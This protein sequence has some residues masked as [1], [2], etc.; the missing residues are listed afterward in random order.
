MTREEQ[1]ERERCEDAL[2]NLLRKAKDKLG[3]CLDVMV[4]LKAQKIN[5][6]THTFFGVADARYNLLK[7]C[8]V[9]DTGPYEKRYTE[10]TSASPIARR[11]ST[12]GGGRTNTLQANRS[13]TPHKTGG[14]E[15]YT[16]PS[17][18]QAW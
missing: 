6:A 15:P 4:H 1:Q 9:G 7:L 3:A 8:H 2:S 18:E 14:R 12:R 11:T 16:L 10:I 17:L 13:D 5:M